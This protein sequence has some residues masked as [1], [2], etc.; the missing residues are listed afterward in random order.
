T[1]IKC[2]SYTLRGKIA[3]DESTSQQEMIRRL[4][5]RSG[6][7]LEV[8]PRVF[9]DQAPATTTTVTAENPVQVVQFIHQT[10]K[11]FVR[12]YRNALGLCW[13]NDATA[14]SERSEE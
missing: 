6:G 14:L 7:L 8:V 11:E 9:S 1:F 3:P 4:K 10:V 12:D 2:T 5:S 13:K